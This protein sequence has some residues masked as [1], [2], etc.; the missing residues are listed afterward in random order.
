MTQSLGIIHFSSPMSP[1]I[2]PGVKFQNESLFQ[3]AFRTTFVENV[4]M[5]ICENKHHF[6]QDKLLL[7]SLS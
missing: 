7:E 3:P 5:K 1:K 4:T 2:V 6:Q